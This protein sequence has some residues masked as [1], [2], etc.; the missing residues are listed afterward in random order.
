MCSINQDIRGLSFNNENLLMTQY[1]DDTEFILD[2]SNTCFETTVMVLTDFA[3]MS[4]LNINY[5]KSQV[6][7]IGSKIYCKDVYLPHLKLNWNPKVFKILGI[8]FTTNIKEISEINFKNKLFEIK[9]IINRWMKRVITPL[10][11]IAIIKSL[12]ISKLNYLF[13]T[14]SNPRGVFLKE[15]N[16]ILFQFVWSSKPDRIKRSVVCRPVCEGGLGMVDIY[17]HMLKLWN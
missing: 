4:G 16:H 13:L 9:Q 11:R 10:G 1:A 14:L 12:L 6:M 15:L 3:S 8:K 17:M 2:G 7:W 5:E